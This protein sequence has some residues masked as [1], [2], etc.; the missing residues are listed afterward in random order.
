MKSK[1]TDARSFISLLQHQDIE[2]QCGN[3]IC[4]D[5]D[6]FV[7]LAIEPLQV[8]ITII[9]ALCLGR[10]LSSIEA[11]IVH[12]TEQY[13]QLLRVSFALTSLYCRTSA[14]AAKLDMNPMAV[15]VE[16]AAPLHK[17]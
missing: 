4:A 1:W 10:C 12:P 7:S 11:E 8:P 17:A 5:L 9:S 15:A 2:L 13:V 3:V 14:A 16:L 6:I